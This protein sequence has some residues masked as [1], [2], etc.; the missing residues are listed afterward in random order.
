MSYYKA[1]AVR[2]AARNN[3]LFILEALA[4]GLEPA[5]RKPGRHVTCPFHGTK[6]R[7]GK[8]DGFRLYKDAH[9]TGG[10]VCNSCGPKPDGF[11]LLMWLNGWSF[12]E[13]LE[14]VGDFLR[15]PKEQTGSTRRK[16]KS[17]AATARPGLARNA[18]SGAAVAESEPEDETVAPPSDEGKVVP[19]FREQAKPWL[20]EMQEEME[21][22]LERQRAYSA[23]LHE[24]IEQVWKECVPYLSEASEPMR[25][26]LQNRGLL[27]PVT[28][29]EQSD[30]LRFHPSLSYYDEDG[31]EVGK[32]PAIVCAIRDVDGNLVTLH[33]TYLTTTGKKAKVENVKKMMPIPD[34]L[35]VNGAAIQLGIPTEGI[36][37][38][39]EGLETALSAYR[40][41]HIP[42][43][44]TVNATLM[45]SF[46]PP[47][48]VHTV[49][50]W[51]DRDKSMTGERSANV[52][53]E[54]LEK[55]GIQ[56]FILL[57]K[58]PIPPREKSVDWNDVL[59]TQ[60][61]LGFPQ[62][63]YLRSFIARRGVRYGHS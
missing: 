36:L 45:E 29:V 8:G 16:T 15:V 31:N 44:S 33:R 55:R 25:R 1:D 32:F 35:D 62:P 46:E 6:N 41:S 2:E 48:G 21:K 59:L 49:L 28:V 57:P 50:V 5:L 24:R 7:N 43:W 47:A 14:A 4:P 26:Y 63:R 56:V 12:K 61:R 10:G 27:F 58:L 40:M 9:V 20:L 19:L 60:G 52:L 17:R 11:E 30:C 39:A 53:K 23:R 22:R 42:V 13:C 51:A 54:R 38:V 34:G 37:G 18:Q 3:W